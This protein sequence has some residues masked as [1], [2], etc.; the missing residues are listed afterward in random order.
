M[1]AEGIAPSAISAF[2]SMFSSLVSGNDGM[3]AKST[4]SGRVGP[5]RGQRELLG[6]SIAVS[7]HWWSI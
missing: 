2:E 7:W 3:I 5:E 6:E 4:I 1:V